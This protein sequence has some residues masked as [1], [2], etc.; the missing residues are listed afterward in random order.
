MPIKH[1]PIVY[2]V[3]LIIWVT[4]SVVL[5]Y[6]CTGADPQSTRLWFYGGV[7]SAVATFIA[8]LACLAITGDSL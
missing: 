8:K 6:F 2:A 5:W 1:D 7:S 3:D 4:V